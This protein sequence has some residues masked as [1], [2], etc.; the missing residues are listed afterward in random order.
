MIKTPN[1]FELASSDYNQSES[2]ANTAEDTL[3]A[4]LQ[5]ISDDIKNNDDYLNFFNCSGNECSR[6]DVSDDPDTL[7]QSI[8]DLN[9]SIKELLIGDLANV[10]VP[11][12]QQDIESKKKVTELTE[13]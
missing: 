11:K 10:G 5:T 1:H 3:M 2:E 4:D 13:V 7:I 12:T 6:I 9:L 8:H